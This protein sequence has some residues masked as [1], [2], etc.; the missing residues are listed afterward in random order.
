LPATG[1]AI[2]LERLLSVLPEKDTPPLL[3]LVGGDV[4]GSKTATALREHGVPTLHLPED[5]E[6]EA[7]AKYASSVDAGWVCYPTSEGV[8]LAA[9]EPD[10]RFEAV[11]IEDVPA[12]VLGKLTQEGV[13]R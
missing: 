11:Q 2:Y 10:S 3:V 9:S 4:E 8:K 12:K 7:A 1:F 5:L 6:P 13:R